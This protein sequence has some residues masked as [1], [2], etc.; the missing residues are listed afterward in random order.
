MNAAH[1]NSVFLAISFLAFNALAD[2]ESNAEYFTL[3][4]DDGVT[5]QGG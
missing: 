2:G 3:V 4:G 1:T 5:Y